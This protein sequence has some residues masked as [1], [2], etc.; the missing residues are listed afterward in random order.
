VPIDRFDG[1]AAQSAVRMKGHEV[2]LSHAPRRTLRSEARS[3]VG[4][5]PC[6]HDSERGSSPRRH[7]DEQ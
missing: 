3:V 6:P 1:L 5:L 4:R 7:D 2:G